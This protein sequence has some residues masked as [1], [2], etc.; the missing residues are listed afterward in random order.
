MN[1]SSKKRVLKSIKS[2]PKVPAEFDSE[3]EDQGSLHTVSSSLRI[4]NNS[5]YKTPRTRTNHKDNSEIWGLDALSGTDSGVC[6]SDRTVPWSHEQ[7]PSKTKSTLM[8]K[9]ADQQSP[10]LGALPAQK[11][12]HKDFRVSILFHF[13]TF[14]ASCV[15]MLAMYSYFSTNM[16]EFNH[17]LVSLTEEFQ[18]FKDAPHK[19]SF[20][21]DSKLFQQVLYSAHSNYLLQK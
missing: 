18:A 4:P 21:A 12:E 3:S 20:S 2:S 5:S 8:C 11:H 1:P 14:I 19:S 6:S 17:T 13:C 10:A 7:H 9:E 15:L 16:N